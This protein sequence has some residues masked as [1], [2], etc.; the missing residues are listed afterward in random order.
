MA[1]VCR[2]TAEHDLTT[3][4]NSVLAVAVEDVLMLVGRILLHRHNG[5]RR[6]SH[7]GYDILARLVLHS[8]PSRQLLLRVE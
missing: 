8:E 3:T 4:R 5:P 1:L 2:D 7:V 6:D